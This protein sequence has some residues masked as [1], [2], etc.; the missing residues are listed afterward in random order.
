MRLSAFRT[1]LKDFEIIELNET[2]GNDLR[3]NYTG[4]QRLFVLL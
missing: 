1:T 4:K 2:D 3:P